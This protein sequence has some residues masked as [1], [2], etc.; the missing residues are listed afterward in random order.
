[1]DPIL[2]LHNNVWNI[3]LEKIYNCQYYKQTLKSLLLVNK[4]YNKI[5]NEIISK[6]I[7]SFKPL[8]CQAKMLSIDT[9]YLICSTYD[10]KMEIKRNNGKKIS[11]I[12]YDNNDNYIKPMKLVEYLH[13]TIYLFDKNYMIYKINDDI[14]L[15]T[16]YL[17][18]ITE[19]L[20]YWSH[21]WIISTIKIDIDI[22][23]LLGNQIFGTPKGNFIFNDNLHN[24]FKELNI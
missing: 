3:I 7:I 23:I 4:I 16:L 2:F 5:A 21:G 1:M 20:K 17:Y 15:I 12:V 24:V 9:D 22:I 18:S 8:I 11:Y 10:A 13:Y 19:N 6:K 14:K